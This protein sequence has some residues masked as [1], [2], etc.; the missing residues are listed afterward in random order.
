MYEFVFKELGVRLP[1]S[2]LVVEI[3]R[4]LRLAPSQLHPNAMAF[5]L[6]FQHLCEYK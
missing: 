6:A 5:V 4:F 3:F 1:F 2:P